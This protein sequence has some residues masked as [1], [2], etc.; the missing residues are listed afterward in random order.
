MLVIKFTCSEATS[1]NHLDYGAGYSPMQH[2]SEE[3][4]SILH[5]DVQLISVIQQFGARSVTDSADMFYGN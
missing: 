2:V 5:L 1:P 3:R 4:T